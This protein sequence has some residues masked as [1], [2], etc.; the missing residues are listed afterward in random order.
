MTF[1]ELLYEHGVPV[2]TE[3]KHFRQGWLNFDCPF[4][5]A[6]TGNHH[7]G[8]NVA[9]HY[10]NCWKCGSH[11]LITTLA[12]ILSISFAECGKLLTDLDIPLSKYI[13]KQ[14]GKLVLPPGISKLSPAHKR[15][16]RGRGFD[17]KELVRRWGIKGIGMASRCAYSIFIPFHYRGEIVSWTT[18]AIHD[19]GWRYMGAKANEEKYN[20]KEL[21]FGEDLAVNSIC[22]VEGPFDVFAI[23]PGAVGLMGLDWSESQLKRIATFPIRY[24]CLDNRPSAQKIARELCSELDLFPGETYNV[25]L[26][27][28]DPAEAKRTNHKE[29][30]KLRKLLLA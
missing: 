24:I 20:A 2:A 7:M 16:L 6:G 21:L 8:Y 25:V 12:E 3:G 10:V 19:R 27:S 11:P 9:R 14:R 1:E 18:R 5:S 29:L 23:G 17:P 13:P 22:V 15:Y 28:K 30:K 4:C 26:R